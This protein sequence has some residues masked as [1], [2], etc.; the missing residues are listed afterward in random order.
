M[1]N[2]NSF[3]EKHLASWRRQNI[4][5]QEYGTHR[6]VPHPWILP[7][8]A[9]K[10]GLWYGIRDSL[11]KYLEANNVARHRDVLTSKVLGFCAQIFIFRFSKIA[12]NLC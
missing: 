7:S 5:M 11:S 8:S 10:E 12:V 9:W 1:R 3:L 6:G 2:F 4:S